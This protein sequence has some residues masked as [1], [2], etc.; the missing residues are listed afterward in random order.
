MNARLYIFIRRQR[1]GRHGVITLRV[2]WQCSLGL[3]YEIVQKRLTFS[4]SEYRAG[5]MAPDALL[6]VRA[7][8]GS[9]GMA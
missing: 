6:F 1:T 2:R 9:E 4:W 3:R 8:D 5:V 7:M